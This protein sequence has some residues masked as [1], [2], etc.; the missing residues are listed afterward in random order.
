MNSAFTFPTQASGTILTADSTATLT[1]K[2]FNTAG[3]GNSFSING[4]A[5]S[6]VTGTGSVV[7]ATSPSLTTPVLGVATATSINKLTLTQPATGATL[8]LAD[9]S[10]LITAGGFATTITA[11]QTANFTLPAQAS[12]TIVTADSTATLTNKTFNTQGTGNAFSINGT[13]VTTSVPVI[14]GG[15]GATTAAAARTNLNPANGFALPAKYAA[16]C[17]TANPWTIAAATHL[18]GATQDIAVYIYEKSTGTQVFA[19]VTV[20]GT[21]DIS[22]QLGAVPTAAQ[23]RAVVIG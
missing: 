18:L 3:V 11:V 1:N 16:D 9:G 7:L 22:I 5:I 13:A 8:T 23:Y 10:S 2:T 21:G 15:T 6:A 20:S 14:V 4:T 17:S 12:G 19:D